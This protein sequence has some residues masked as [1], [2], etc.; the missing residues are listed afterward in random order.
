MFDN[1]TAR[2]SAVIRSVTGTGR[3]TEANIEEAVRTMRMALLE[4]DVALPVV[5]TIIQRVKSRAIGAEV[6]ASLSPGQA[7]VKIMH[8]ELIAIMGGEA[9]PLQT[10]VRPPLVILLAGLQGAG[11]TST[12]VKL[13]YW[14]RERQKK[15]VAVVSCDIYRPAAIEQLRVSALGV[16]LGFIADAGERNP[17]MIA[18]SALQYARTHGVEILIVD[19]AGRLH[20]D[21]EMMAEIGEIHRAVEPHET[22]F[23]VDSMAG[24]DVANTAG[25]FN[26]TLP[27]T[28]IILTKTDGDARGGAALSV[29]EVTG[30][31]IKFMGTGEKPDAFSVFHPQRIVSR[32]LGM[33]DVLSL[34]EEA[35]HKLDKGKAEKLAQK[36]RQG[37][38]FNLEDLREQMQSMRKLGGM[39]GLLEKIPGMALPPGAQQ[40]IDERQISRSIAIIDSMTPLERRKP[41][42]INGSRKRRIAAGAGMQIQDVNR[43]LKQHLEMSKM[44]KRFAKGGMQKLMRG[45]QARTGPGRKPG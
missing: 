34:V 24:Q 20:I 44:M 37:K 18:K 31:P 14:L 12:A 1:L 32:I 33:G 35:E 26:S 22:L 15:S 28:G 16:G 30:K 6:S 13:G 40:Q 11:K 2:F 45:L 41:D 38:G 8:D 36:V 21:Q 9:V 5:K 19:T 29:R 39:A 10:N 43:L 17:V 25:V 23:V 3:L 4:A 7:F 27:L 42:V